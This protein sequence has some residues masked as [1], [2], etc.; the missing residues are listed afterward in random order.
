MSL[1]KR[2]QAAHVVFELYRGSDCRG[3]P[4]SVGLGKDAN[5][6]LDLLTSVLLDQPHKRGTLGDV[7]ENALI[8]GVNGIEFFN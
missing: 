2:G 3:I 8:G 1:E 7:F 6:L 4:L 5:N